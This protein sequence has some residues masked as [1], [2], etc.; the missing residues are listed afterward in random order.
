MRTRM[1][2]AIATGKLG[3]KADVP[4]LMAVVEENNDKDEYLRHG[5]VE[6]M[7]RIGDGAAIFAFAKSKSPAVRRAIVLALRR[8]QDGRIGKMLQDKDLSI[9]LRPSRRSMTTM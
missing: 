8:L 5:A 7:V 3:S 4:A 1:L 2:A 6:G 9:A